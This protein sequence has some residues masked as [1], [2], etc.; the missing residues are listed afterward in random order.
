M[1]HDQIFYLRDDNGIELLPIAIPLDENCKFHSQVS[2]HFTFMFPLV[3][4][5]CFH[6]FRSKFPRGDIR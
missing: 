3:S 5:T 4:Q 6:L 2:S 1:A